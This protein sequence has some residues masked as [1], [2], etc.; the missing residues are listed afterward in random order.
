MWSH[1]IP[2]TSHS[3][4]TTLMESLFTQIKTETVYCPVKGKKRMLVF[5]DKY[6]KSE[7][8][9]YKWNQEKLKYTKQIIA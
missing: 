7:E 4:L 9:T 5:M 3:S 1:A 6:N 8:R 2:E